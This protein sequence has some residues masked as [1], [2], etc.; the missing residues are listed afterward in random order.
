MS[1]VKAW[2]GTNN[3]GS[4]S[5][6]VGIPCGTTTSP[7]TGTSALP[8]LPGRAMPKSG[9]KKSKKKHAQ[10]PASQ[11]DADDETFDYHN[12]DEFDDD[13]DDDNDAGPASLTAPTG[14]DNTVA[15]PGAEDGEDDD[16]NDGAD[17]DDGP[18][19]PKGKGKTGGFQSMGLS[20]YIYRSVMRKGYRVPTPIQ[21]K[22]IPPILAGRDVVA[23]ART[24]SG[25]TAAFLIPLIEKLGAHASVVGVRGLVLSPTRELAMQVR[26]LPRMAAGCR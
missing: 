3:F 15:F 18:R 17:G 2:E 20:P 8:T 6:S 10:H 1:R 22:A 7:W 12:D 11:A 14:F 16:E 13:D 23:M 26:C 4:P 5:S 9:S 25:K 21:R 24:G 19:K